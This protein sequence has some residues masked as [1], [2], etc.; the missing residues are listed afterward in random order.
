MRLFDILKRR[1]SFLP[2]PCKYRVFSTDHS[3]VPQQTQDESTFP[4][5]TSGYIILEGF[6]Q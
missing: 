3:R 2:L 5:F 1:S 6:T 4:A